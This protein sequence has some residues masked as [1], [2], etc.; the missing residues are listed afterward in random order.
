MR[1]DGAMRTFLMLCLGCGLLAVACLAPGIGGGFV[2]DDRASIEK[3]AELRVDQLQGEEL[4]RA[5]YSFQPGGGSRAIPMLTF[6]L[7]QWR[8]GGRPE[9]FKVTNLLIHFV[10]V[11]VLACFA[12]KLL[13]MA[14]WSPKRAALAALLVASVWG[15]HPLQVSSVLYVVQRMQTL[16]T[17]FMLLALWAYLTMRKA[18]MEGGRSRKYGLLVALFWALGLACKE[19]AVLFPAYALAVELTVLRFTAKSPRLARGLRNGYAAMTVL[20]GAL[21]VL[22][23][24]PRFWHWGPYPFREFSSVERLLTQGPVLFLY[25]QQILFPL[26]ASMPFYYD[27]FRI[28]HGLLDPPVTLFAWCCLVGLMVWAWRWR[29]DRPIFALG[30]FLFFSGHFITSNI[31]NLELAFEHRNHFPMI[32]VILA[33]MDLCVMALARVRRDLRLVRLGQICGGLAMLMLVAATMTRAYMW[34]EPM[35]LAAGTLRLAP[36]SERAWL[37]FAATNVD[38]SG[39]QPDSPWLESAI[40]ANSLG[41]EVTHSAV[42]QANVVIYKSI[43][44][45]ASSEDWL[46]LEGLV[47]RAPINVQNRGIAGILLNNVDGG[48]ALDKNAVAGVLDVMAR[49]VDFDRDENLRIAT[50]VYNET[51]R[52]GRAFKYMR[53]AVELSPPDDPAIAAL[54]GQLSSIGREDWVLQLRHSLPQ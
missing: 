22:L 39:F 3:N 10:T 19:D 31:V 38:R 16:V 35:R 48:L 46:S 30:V 36:Q 29:R 42:M 4:L 25:L 43:K 5:A 45:T 9:A 34:G 23:I 20:A 33:V 32:G 13:L 27:N 11:F 24:L 8:G 18:Q 14:G 44:G 37:M 12:R 53:R 52:P 51:E 40:T 26:P 1:I 47:A 50:F 6:A 54:F 41:V 7:D 21:F 49:R 15:A 17:L 2:M 28:S